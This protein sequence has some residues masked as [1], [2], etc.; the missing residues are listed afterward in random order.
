M[1]PQSLPWATHE[2]VGDESGRTGI[3]KRPRQ[4]RLRAEVDQHR[5]GMALSG[6][7]LIVALSRRLAAY[8]F[9]TDDDGTDPATA[10]ERPRLTAMSA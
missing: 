5:S 7:W 3:T 8:G 4:Q 2:L 1:E 9:T 10:V 6:V